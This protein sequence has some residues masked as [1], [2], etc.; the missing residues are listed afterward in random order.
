ME[1]SEPGIARCRLVLSCC[2]VIEDGVTR[3]EEASPKVGRRMVLEMPIKAILFDFDLTIVDIKTDEMKDHIWQVLAS[4]LQYRG[5]A[6]KA[7]ELREIYFHIGARE[8]GSERGAASGSR[9]RAALR[10]APGAFG[11]RI[12][13]PIWPGRSRKPFPLALDRAIPL[14]PGVSSVLETLAECYRLALVSDSQALYIQPELRTTS[15][16]EL[17]E[18]V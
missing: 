12:L 1:G 14:V 10:Q 3:V 18:V 5:A 16:A 9:R 6:A 4:F 8:P 11:R 2:K 13:R 15:L 7:A 17:F